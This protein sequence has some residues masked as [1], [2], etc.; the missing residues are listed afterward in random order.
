MVWVGGVAGHA[1]SLQTR[2]PAWLGGG[3]QDYQRELFTEPAG[4]SVVRSTPRVR[5]LS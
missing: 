5:A 2:K 3:V 1:S 4:I